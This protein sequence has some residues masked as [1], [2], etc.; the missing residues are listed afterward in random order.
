MFL[1]LHPYT[2]GYGRCPCLK[3]SQLPTPTAAEVAEYDQTVG[4]A[5]DPGLKAPPVSKFDFVKRI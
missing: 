5:L 4:V 3:L 1:S 2:M